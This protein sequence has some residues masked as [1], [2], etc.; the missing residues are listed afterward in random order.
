MSAVSRR[1]RE[2]GTLKALGWKSRRVVGQVLGESV[3]PGR[4]RRAC[5]ASSS[6]SLGARL[7]AWF[8]PELKATL[9]APA[10]RCPAAAPGAGGAIRAMAD[11][12][13]TV[14]VQ[15]TAPVSLELVLIAVGLAVAGGLVAG[16]LGGWRASRLRP[17]DALRRLD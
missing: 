15:L 9:G 3:V 2:F 11:A 4:D 10:A 13:Q 12:A 5:S 1:V 7:I 16:A 6:A 8:S 14:T 17:A